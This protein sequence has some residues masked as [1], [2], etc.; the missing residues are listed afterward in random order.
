M[1]D[2]EF[3][4]DEV[5]AEK[6]A[7]KRKQSDKSRR[8]RERV[9]AAKTYYCAPCDY[10]CPDQGTLDL[11]KTTKKHLKKVATGTS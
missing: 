8:Y 1:K 4:I 11:H 7:K 6:R 10:A 5:E 9:I 2:L 3:G